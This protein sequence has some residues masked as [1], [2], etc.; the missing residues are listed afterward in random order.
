MSSPPPDL[1]A[2]LDAL[3][4]AGRFVEAA[5]LCLEHDQPR[6]AAELLAA[7]WDW[8]GAIRIAEQEGLLALAYRFS[9]EG[10]RRDDAR[11]LMTALV[12]APEQ[13]L[14]AARHASDRGRPVDA[15]R[16]EEAAGDVESAAASY[17]RAGDLFEAAR[18]NEAMGR[19]RRAGLLYERRVREAPDDG[20]AALRLGRILAHFGRFD[21]AVR[22]LQSAEA[23]PERRPA[24]LRLM[25][26][27]FTALGMP[28]A[29][30][31]RLDQL[32]AEDPSLPVT[33]PEFLQERFGDERGI[34]GLAADDEG[35]RSRLLAGRYRILRPLGAGATGRVLLAH[36]G[37]YDR[38]V[39]VKV[40][41]VG[42]GAAGRDAYVRFAR[43]ARVAAGLSHVNVVRVFEFNPEGPFLV[44]EYMP[45]GTLEDR[46]VEGERALP[47]PV[48]QH[49]LVSVLAGLEAV[50]RR[51]V[52]HR[53]L[54]PANVFFG[55]TG[56]VKLGD[57]G[58]AHLT[59][60]GATLT[61]AMLGTLAYMSPEQITGAHRPDATTDLYALGVILQR[62]LTGTLPFPGPDF[63]TQHLKDVPRP[64]SEI[65]PELGDRFDGL[66][67]RLLA[68]DAADRPAA[69]GEVREMVEGLL[70]DEPERTA[71]QVA[72]GD[73]GVTPARVAAGDA[74]VIAAGGER[75]SSSPPPAERYVSVEPLPDGATLA[76]D[77]LLHR[78][79]RILACDPGEA[80]RLR[81]WALAD[82]PWLQAVYAVDVEGG[83][84]VLEHPGGRTLAEVSVSAER[85]WRALSDVRRALERIHGAG[86]AH[87]AVDEGMVRVSDGRA[88]L[89]LP[90][91]G[92]T[93][94][95]DADLAALAELERAVE[96]QGR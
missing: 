80:E 64:P 56:D 70:W 65:A 1:E 34:A 20:E 13:A 23:D 67:A 68:K 78:P 25:V 76:R 30:A 35:D 43:E 50:H 84:A 37:F 53:D 40:L 44:M 15:A 29:A 26:A 4:R 88:V 7:V 58:V 8:Q 75:P 16:L 24:A 31:S 18:C 10:D 49:V 47:L 87:G 89:M 66:V 95:R 60:L 5:R 90:R 54:K 92:S 2:S 74:G 12:E 83:R 3:R 27:C 36:D 32:R 77:L 45:G 21:H 42:S 61:G 51:G 94:D 33:V 79:V 57:F 28:E 73:A 96:P 63:V 86:L 14:E 9:L 22:A 11:R 39:A 69:A 81:A 17:E 41:T 55:A 46:L 59:D 52:V 91:G 6:R 82:S 62:M 72:T 93:A 38:E 85:R 71:L 48:I 19:Y